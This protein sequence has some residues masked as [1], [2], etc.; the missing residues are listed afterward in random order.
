MTVLSVLDGAIAMAYAVAGLFFLRF[1]VR[2]R[3]ELFLTFAI[4]FWLFAVNQALIG[5]FGG[6]AETQMAFYV[7]RLLGFLLIIFAIIRK[8]RKRR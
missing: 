2:A 4:A 1:W 3:D 8:N 7:P 6:G 5:V